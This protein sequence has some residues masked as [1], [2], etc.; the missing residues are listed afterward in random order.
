MGE[1]AGLE[2]IKV[3]SRKKGESKM[4]RKVDRRDLTGSSLYTHARGRGS[5]GSLVKTAYN[6][7][8]AATIRTW[9]ILLFRLLRSTEKMRGLWPLILLSRSPARDATFLNRYPLENS[10]K[11]LKVDVVT[12]LL[13]AY[14]YMYLG[15]Y[16]EYFERH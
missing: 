6:P 8:S 15:S 7:H 4:K 14:S 16:V 3:D 2:G 12:Q 9:G 13:E 1:G 11:R 10:S 5:D